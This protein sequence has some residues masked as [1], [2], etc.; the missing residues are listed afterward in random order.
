M[1]LPSFQKRI[2]VAKKYL[3]N[4]LPPEVKDTRKHGRFPVYVIIQNYNRKN[5]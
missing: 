2:H 5:N 3:N 1:E 4:F